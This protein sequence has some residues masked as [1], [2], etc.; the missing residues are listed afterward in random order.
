MR[1]TLPARPMS[2]TWPT[3]PTRPARGTRPAHRTNATPKHAA[4][5]AALMA[6]A[7]AL[8]S[9]GIVRDLPRLVEADEVATVRRAVVL[10][11]TGDPN[12]RWFG[13]PGST[14]HYPLAAVVHVAVAES[15]TDWLVAPPSSA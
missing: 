13:H 14:Y 7:A 8:L 2:P 5:V 12:P 11:A 10:A 4:I 9:W 15:P 1:I 6:A 3:R